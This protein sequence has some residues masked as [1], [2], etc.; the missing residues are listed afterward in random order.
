[1]IAKG[2]HIWYKCHVGQSLKVLPARFFRSAAGDEP[3]RQW[4]KGLLKEGGTCVEIN[5]P[6]ARLKAT[7][8]SVRPTLVILTAQLV[9]TAANLLE[10]SRLLA[11]MGIPLAYGGRI[12]NQHM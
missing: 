8:N 3:I 2:Y 9:T 7:I 10:M 1:M 6:L 4:L 5:V 12:F 11:S